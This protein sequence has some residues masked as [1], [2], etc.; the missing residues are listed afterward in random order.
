M[1][2]EYF[3]PEIEPY[4]HGQLE[5]SDTHTLYWEQCGNPDGEP[6][7]FLHGGP[8]AGSTTT[9]RRFF[10]PDHFRIILFDQ[11]GCGRSQ[12][13]GELSDNTIDHIVSDIETL[14]GVLEIDTW[15]VFGGSWGST[16][17]LYY[18]QEKPENC[19]SLTLRGIWLLRDEELHWWLYS[20][21]FIQPEL[22]RTFSEHLPVDERGDLL[23]GY[24]KRLNSEDKDVALTAAR[25]WSTYEGS[26][27][28]LLP[29]EEFASHFAV[30][31]TAWCVARL[32][33]HYFR[34]GRF[35]PDDLLLRRMD[36]LRNIPAFIVHGRYDIVCPITS[37]DELSRRWP[38]ASYVIVPDAGHSSHEL[39]IT[40]EL[41]DATQRIA[42]TGSP[43]L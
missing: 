21:R 1:V 39:G 42:K 32:E 11:R 12:P 6:I 41:V 27:C 30:D 37:A 3:Y 19:R 8:G 29:N 43:T 13:L 10:D 33:A 16:L 14:R 5:V 17:S 38:E 7:L 23:E 2:N 34:N 4:A 18:A 26:C 9:D 24:W 22:W 31:D 40:K 25:H 15:H 35:E 28:T 36:R 20:M